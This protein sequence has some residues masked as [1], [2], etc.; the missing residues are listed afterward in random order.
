MR[1]TSTELLACVFNILLQYL[2][3]L[4]QFQASKSNVWDDVN[5]SSCHWLHKSKMIIS[6]AVISLLPY[7]HESVLH[8]LSGEKPDSSSTND[9]SIQTDSFHQW[10][11]YFWVVTLV[12]VSTVIFWNMW[13]NVHQTNNLNITGTEAEI[14]KVMVRT[15]T[16]AVMRLKNRSN[17][18][19]NLILLLYWIS[20]YL[21]I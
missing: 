13:P 4:S 2:R 17:F 15:I 19:W 18:H 10:F 8:L 12:R 7:V 3:Q 11:L 5:G 14:W 16:A 9:M 1:Q 21:F 6:I 20:Q